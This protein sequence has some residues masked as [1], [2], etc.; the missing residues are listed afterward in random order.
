MSGVVPIEL[1]GGGVILE[2]SS[3]IGFENHHLLFFEGS[4]HTPWEWGRA[5]EDQMI[6]FVSENLFNDHDCANSIGVNDVGVGENVF[7]LPN[8]VNNEFSVSGLNNYKSLTIKTHCDKVVYHKEGF[9]KNNNID[10]LARGLYIVE[11]LKDDKEGVIT[12]K[13][14]KL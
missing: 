6:S 5:I 11:L 8:P 9:S 2:R 12:K 13:I 1:C 4:D 7:I 10:F 14:I 3:L